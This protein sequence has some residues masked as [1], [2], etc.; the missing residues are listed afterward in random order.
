MKIEF[1]NATSSLF[2]VLIKAQRMKKDRSKK[3][4]QK[5]SEHI[6]AARNQLYVPVFHRDFCYS[7]R[8]YSYQHPVLL[9]SKKAS[10]IITLRLHRSIQ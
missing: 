8:M 2:C 7:L 1:F 5:E 3:K 9:S 10:Y 6:Q 4:T